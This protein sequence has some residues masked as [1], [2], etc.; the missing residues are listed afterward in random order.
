MF[1]PPLSFLW[2]VF[3]WWWTRNSTFRRSMNRISQLFAEIARWRDRR[4][5]ARKK[6]RVIWAF[7]MFHSG[8]GGIRE[9]KKGRTKTQHPNK[10]QKRKLSNT[11]NMTRNV[12]QFWDVYRYFLQVGWFLQALSMGITTTTRGWWNRMI[13]PRHDLTIISSPDWWLCFSCFSRSPEECCTKWR[14]RHLCKSCKRTPGS[15]WP[16]RFIDVV[17]IYISII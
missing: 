3:S 6:Q 2:N 4:I 17:K 10:K 7:R 5:K 14:V 8:V 11:N 12:H 13:Q 16:L 1:W 9:K 15:S